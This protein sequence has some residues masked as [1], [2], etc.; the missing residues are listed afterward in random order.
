MLAF[1]V[2]LFTAAQGSDALSIGRPYGETDIAPSGSMKA[3]LPALLIAFTLAF[4]SSALACE[5]HLDG[6][7]NSGD[8][9]A[10]VQK[11]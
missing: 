11:R 1:P 5:K 9:Q 3:L 2:T 10:E 7:Q 4:G 6:H 8:T